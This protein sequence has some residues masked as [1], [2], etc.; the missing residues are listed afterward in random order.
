VHIYTS[1]DTDQPRKSKM[2]GN[3]FHAVS[4]IG[5]GTAC[6]VSEAC[7]GKRFLSTEAPRLPLAECDAKRCECRYRHYA[8]RRGAPR[9]REEKVAIGTTATVR[10]IG[11]NRREK[12]GRR[13]T[14]GAAE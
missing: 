11:A 7:R 1:V 3:R 14:D 8:D 2:T 12:R 4:I 9:R 13:A 10:V 5:S 6:A